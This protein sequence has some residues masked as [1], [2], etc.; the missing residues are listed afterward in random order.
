[1]TDMQIVVYTTIKYT[2]MH[3]IMS[4]PWTL[5]KQMFMYELKAPD[6]I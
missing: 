4:V 5:F 1:V 3:G 2:F 6:I